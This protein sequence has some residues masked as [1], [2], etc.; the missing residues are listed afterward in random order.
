MNKIASG[1]KGVEIV[2]FAGMACMSLHSNY[3]F[4]IVCSNIRS[5]SLLLLS[6]SIN[7]IMSRL[8]TFQFTFRRNV[9]ARTEPYASE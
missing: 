6:L 1:G 9:I 3:P 8:R 7:I 5:S 2:R 4:F